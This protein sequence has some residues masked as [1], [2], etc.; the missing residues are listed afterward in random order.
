MTTGIKRIFP[1]IPAG[2]DTGQVLTKSSSTDYAASWQDAAGGADDHVRVG[3][4]AARATGRL[5]H[6][7]PREAAFLERAPELVGPGALLG[8]LDRLLGD[9]VAEEPGDRVGEER[10]QLHQALKWGAPKWPPCMVLGV[11]AASA[12]APDG[13]GAV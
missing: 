4:D 5:R 11:T 7:R 12:G 9:E 1:G 13:P 10:A 8:G 3:P 6:E 2:G